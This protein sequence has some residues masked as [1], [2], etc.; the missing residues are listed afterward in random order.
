M[1][2]KD[3]TF[4]TLW[5]AIGL[6]ALTMLFGIQI[7][8]ALF[9]LLLYVLG[10]RMGW[11]A[12]GIGAL[13]LLVFT[14]GFLAELFRRLLGSRVLLIVTV[15]GVAIVRLALQLWPDA[16][17][18]YLILSIIG[19]VCFVLFFPVYLAALRPCPPP[20]MVKF[21]YGLELGLLLAILLNG[22]YNT[23]EFNWQPGVAN[24][25]TA[26]GLVLLQVSCLARVL[27]QLPP[28]PQDQ[29]AP[30]KSALPWAM[31]G[32]FIFLQLLVFL[33]LAQ[34]SAS[35][36]WQLPI[37]LALATVAGLVGLGAAGFVA[38]RGMGL[39]GVLVAS[40]ILLTLALMANNAPWS[41]AVTLILSQGILGGLLMLVLLNTRGGDGRAHTIRN[42]TIANGM[43]WLLLV[44]F[45]FLY[46]AGYQ[47]PLFPNT[48]LPP[49]AALLIIL[50]ALAASRQLPSEGRQTP[51][52]VFRGTLL[53]VVVAA[54]IVVFKYVTWSTPTAV[55]PSG[56]PVRVMTYNLHNGVNP[57][58]QLNLEALA[59]A[60]EAQNPDVVALQEVSR[61]WIINGSTD[62]LQWL[63][64]RL[65]MPYVWNPTE[66]D[67]W[68]NAIFSRYPII[69]SEA[70]ALPPDD[71]LLHRGFILAQID[72]G[73]AAPLNI[74]DTHYHH[75]EEDSGI[76]VVQS[77]AILAFW[78]ER[79]T[80]LLVGDLNAGPDSP[81]MI[82]LHD[83]GFID[84]I[85]A[86]GIIPGYTYSSTNPDRRL[87]YIWYTA[88]LTAANVLITTDTASDH[89]GVAATIS[90]E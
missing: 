46:Y 80:T 22:L 76:R 67:T 60:I 64:Q 88:D 77:Q 2:G 84:A 81:E 78:Q 26:L 73:A 13:A 20:E 68:G 48:V 32:P 86:A 39:I 12:I 40:A 35:A 9:P 17:L 44:I 75:L 62:M 3:H 71:L 54:A 38:S 59:R 33:N 82:M 37:T 36:G 42:I 56:G 24:A 65:G 15:A 10:D 25:V 66:G 61:G 31:I 28:T 16:P 23:Y 41:T 74:I 79:P 7:L 18:A 85:T 14:L 5:A 52:F 57:W 87:D 47:L 72:I 58:G 55:T 34:L 45:I 27:S 51:P 50:A 11:T 8:R 43:G 19:A 30:F 6:P 29:D 1:P 83:A 21:G 70:H 69:A 49:A 89:L 90:M 4:T 53:L 63:G